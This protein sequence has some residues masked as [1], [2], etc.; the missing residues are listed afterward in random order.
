MLKPILIVTAVL[1]VGAIASAYLSYR[2]A[3]GEAEQAMTSIAARAAKPL[4]LF[5]ESMVEG[6]PEIARRYFKHAI[7]P[8]TLLYTSVRLEMSGTFLLGD[9]SSYRTYSMTA[10]QMLTPPSEFVWIP[11]MQSGM[12]QISGSDALVQ[13]KS[14]TRFWINGLV[15]VVNQMASPDLNRSALTR[16]AMEAIWVPASLLPGTGVTW[17]QTGPDTARL[18]FPTGIEPIDLTLGAS[19]NVLNIA[20]LRWSDANPDKTFQLQPFGG[21]MLA[22]TTFEGFT[23]PTDIRVGNHFGTGNYLPFFQ[24][25][26]TLAQYL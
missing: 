25:H 23:I 8:G 18:T 15:P 24:A 9:K 12:M 4:G 26:V 21:T 11:S 13:G 6:L 14:W 3:S 19:G 17:E 5:D 7:E 16:A 10:R 20:T 1:L 22:E 2:R